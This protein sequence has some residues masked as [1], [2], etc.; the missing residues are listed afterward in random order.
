[1]VWVTGQ[2]HNYLYLLRI[3]SGKA[4]RVVTRQSYVDSG[5]L[6]RP[7]GSGLFL[8]V[9][10]DPQSRELMLQAGSRRLPLDGA[11]RALWRK[12]AGGLWSTLCLYREGELQL[13][14]RQRTLG[15][16]VMQVADITYDHLDETEDDFLMYL[17]YLINSPEGRVNFLA[18]NDPLVGPWELLD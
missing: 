2:R 5:G 9:Y 4:K 1:M 10:A 8:A 6:G 12:R 18:K 7:V 13:Q 11:T 17:E 3:A 14:V 15:R 16:F